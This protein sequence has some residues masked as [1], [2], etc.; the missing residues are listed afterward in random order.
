M[1][2]GEASSEASVV[3]ATKLPWEVID[4]V[5]RSPDDDNSSQAAPS[6]PSSAA[7]ADFDTGALLW[8]RS[9][10][11]ASAEKAKRRADSPRSPLCSNWGTMLIVSRI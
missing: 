2:G 5:A 11:E 7:S 9:E 10:D 3:T 6:S 8:M 4:G 1:D